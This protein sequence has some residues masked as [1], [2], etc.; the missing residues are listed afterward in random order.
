M[1][2]EESSLNS[3]IRFGWNIFSENIG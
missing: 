2:T 3:V 1:K